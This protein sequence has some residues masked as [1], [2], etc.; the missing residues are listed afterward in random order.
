[1]PSNTEHRILLLVYS[2]V[3]S[4][5]GSVSSYSSGIA[6]VV[7]CLIPFIYLLE[8]EDV[9]VY[10]EFKINCPLPVSGLLMRLLV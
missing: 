7:F 10:I 8:T 5:G 2:L 1:V 3:P 4:S 9:G 6:Q